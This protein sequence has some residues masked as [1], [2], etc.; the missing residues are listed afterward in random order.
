MKIVKGVLTNSHSEEK[1]ELSFEDDEVAALNCYAADV[2]KLMQRS[3]LRAPSNFSIFLK[4]EGLQTEQP[5]SS[6]ET[7]Q[8]DEEQWAAFLH[9]FRPL[10]GLNNDK[11]L[12]GFLRVRKL[13]KRKGSAYPLFCSQLNHLLAQFQS[14]ILPFEITF[15]ID[16]NHYDIEGTFVLWMNAME[17]HRDADKR[18]VLDKINRFLPENGLRTLMANIAV[19]KLRAMCRLREMLI[20][21]FA[22]P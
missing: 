20:S 22:P 13:L 17:F 5:T 18:R 19:E 8:F 2:E 21:I 1:F 4:F 7:G 3:F 11:E 9:L 14:K 10:A 6:V 12:Y 15:G 16:G